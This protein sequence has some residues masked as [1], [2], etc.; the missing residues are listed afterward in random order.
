M[1][2]FMWSFPIPFVD[3]AEWFDDWDYRQGI[4]ISGSLG[5]GTNYQ[6]YLNVPYDSNM[7]EDFDDLRFTDDDGSTLLDYWLEEWIGSSYAK[8]WVEVADNLNSTQIIYMYYGN[9]AVSTVSNGTNTFL[10]YEDWASETVDPAKWDTITNDGS[11]SFDDTF[12]D[13]GSVLQLQGNA[14]TN[15]YELRT[16]GTVSAPISIVSRV[17]LELC[18]TASQRTIFGMGSTAFA[19]M[20]LVRSVDGTDNSFLVFD[21]DVNQDDTPIS[22]DYFGQFERFMITRDGTDGRLYNSPSNDLIATGD[23]DPDSIARNMINLYVRDSEKSLYCDWVFG[24][25]FISPEPSVLI[26]EWQD[27][28][29]AKFI[30]PIGWDPTFQF[31]FDAFFIVL[32]LIMIPF[33]TLYLVRGGRKEMSTDKLFYALIL[34]FVGCGLFIGGILP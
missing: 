30:F 31:G 2:L 4:T 8:I 21:D 9:D 25:K 15:V 7:Q 33:S 20:A 29:E 27:A 32:G 28:G 22:A 18:V 1:V 14:G 26:G 10:F 13:H 34:L 12:A 5:A 11:I 16:T 24:R 19:P 3:G 23:M 17:N 6:V